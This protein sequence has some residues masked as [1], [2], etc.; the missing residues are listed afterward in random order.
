M[1]EKQYF[2]ERILA[3]VATPLAAAVLVGLISFL[4]SRML[5]ALDEKTAPMVGLLVALNILF[6]C[7][8]VASGRVKPR[9]TLAVAAIGAAVLIAGGALGLAVGERPIGEEGEAA[10]ER[11]AA[12]AE[13]EGPAGASPIVN[14]TDNV[15]V[16]AE[17]TVKVGQ[18][19]VWDQSGIAPHTVTADDESFDS[20]PDCSGANQAAC[21]QRGDTYTRTFDKPGR[22]GY[23]CRIHGGP[24]VGMA[25]SVVVE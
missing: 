13:H 24:G 1:N 10:A 19:V 7:S 25:G 23:Y 11:P 3:P 18:D 5:L 16:P 6:A 12:S 8:L 22:Y 9:F 15:F 14:V 21:M 4:M 20:H 2:R 17:T